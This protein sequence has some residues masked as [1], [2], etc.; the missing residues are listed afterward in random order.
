M[1]LLV[2]MLVLNKCSF[3]CP[4]NKASHSELSVLECHNYM[5]AGIKDFETI[6]L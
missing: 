1:F 2:V 4:N 5:H 3:T 6:Y